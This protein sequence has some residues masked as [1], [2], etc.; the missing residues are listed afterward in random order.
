MPDHVPEQVQSHFND[1]MLLARHQKAKSLELRIITS[2]AQYESESGDYINGLKQPSSIH[3]SLKE[4]LDTYDLK[5][6]KTCLS[7]PH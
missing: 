6:A 7:H 2:I 5:R 4:G 1:A 3:N